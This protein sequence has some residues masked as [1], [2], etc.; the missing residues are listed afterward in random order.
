[1]S[2]EGLNRSGDDNLLTYQF[3]NDLCGA[4]V[5]SRCLGQKVI[6]GHIRQPILSVYRDIRKL[7]PSFLLLL[8]TKQKNMMEDAYSG[9]FA[10]SS[11][12]QCLCEINEKVSAICCPAVVP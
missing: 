11:V 1:M 5:I 9:N 6:D 8:V 4:F 12:S 7:S 2:K 3:V 10:S